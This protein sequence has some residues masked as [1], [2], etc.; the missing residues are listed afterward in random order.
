M[1]RRWVFR[2]ISLPQW[3]NEREGSDA[4]DEY[5]RGSIPQWT[6]ER[7]GSDATEEF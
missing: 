3:L 7:G 4:A 1:D 2:R 5:W 6:D